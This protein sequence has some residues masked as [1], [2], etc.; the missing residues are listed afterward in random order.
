M[1]NIKPPKH[2]L[3]DIYK[4]ISLI[5]VYVVIL[6]HVLRLTIFTYKY[7][8]NFDYG[9]ILKT[10]CGKEFFEAET[11]RFHFNKN[12]NDIK[13]NDFYDNK[14]FSILMLIFST[15]F[16]FS[17]ASL[18]SYII[19][20]LFYNKSFIDVVL[21]QKSSS[22]SKNSIINNIKNSTGPLSFI[23]ELFQSLYT[24]YNNKAGL[25]RKDV[26]LLSLFIILS[27]ISIMYIQI[28]YP[29][30]IYSDLF[31]ISI[32][33]LDYFQN[34]FEYIPNII[35][36]PFR[37]FYE[38]TKLG[39]KGSNYNYINV[40]LVLVI[41]MRIVYFTLS[42]SDDGI[43][44]KYLSHNIKNLL[45][46]NNIYGFIAFLIIIIIYKFSLQN[47]KIIINIYK[48]NEN[49][50]NNETLSSDIYEYLNSV[51]GFNYKSNDT[52]SSSIFLALTLL[53][54]IIVTILL[55]PN[56]NNDNNVSIILYG[57]CVMLLLYILISSSI[58][59]VSE[60]EKRL[61]K[62]IVSEPTK[63]YKQNINKI[64]NNFD[65]VI[66]IE[67]NKYVENDKYINICQNVGNAILCTLYSH[68]FENIN[69][70]DNDSEYPTD[71]IDITPE[72]KYTNFCEKKLSYNFKD[73]PKYQIHYYM[74]QK[75]RK[76]SMLYNN[77]A[78][79]NP[80]IKVFNLLK[81]N[82]LNI[83]ELPSTFANII[84]NSISNVLENKLYYDY[85]SDII[86]LNDT[87]TNNKLMNIL[88][89]ETNKKE[90]DSKY[91][92]V[93]TKVISKYVEIY[94]DLKNVIRTEQKTKEQ[95]VD[96][97]E[98]ISIT[99]SNK[100]NEINKILSRGYILDDNA[101]IMKYII[102]N[103]NNLNKLHKFNSD[104]SIELYHNRM[105]D[106]IT[107]KSGKLYEIIELERYFKSS[108]R[109]FEDLYNNM[110]AIDPLNNT[111]DTP[112]YYKKFNEKKE[113]YNSHI[114][115]MEQMKKNIINI[116]EI[117]YKDVYNYSQDNATIIINDITE[118][119]ESKI[120]KKTTNKSLDIIKSDILN[121]LSSINYIQ[122][123]IEKS[124]R[125]Y[126]STE[127]IELNSKMSKLSLENAYKVDR[128]IY[129]VL[130]NYII[131]IGL[132]KI[133]I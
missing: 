117:E 128:M 52:I 46:S 50:E 97:I 28:L 102:Y 56:M 2:I 58:N 8:T 100:F 41:M 77:N 78:C 113:I 21:G 91:L 110:D 14:F 7:R 51:W 74:K 79:T 120:N 123:N 112:S 122:S 114:L 62:F 99:I 101:K 23:K 71:K 129:V 43:I 64:R 66:D 85:L 59:T 115:N 42:E 39:I 90:I 36:I 98:Q 29:Y 10:L 106:I 33:P 88:A 116:L 65:R 40:W 67:Y 30:S 83:N 60:Y 11:S 127:D 72:F 121:I 94:T 80:N 68:L 53:F 75:N 70:L 92:D 22:S 37:L 57:V 1:D 38:K 124:K 81:K 86:V 119:Y 111:I 105:F 3:F 31:D 131:I 107:S 18:L 104:K 54:F 69:M 63:L 45:L 125:N 108:L 76:K 103:Y 47:L 133:I 20:N 87:K 4:Y 9:K 96:A 84:Y 35:L 132:S 19:S 13:K 93:I 130:I 27:I 6:L 24:I 49:N 44:S 15:L 16:T 32:T 34:V 89:L 118:M 5:V 17:M 25:E 109:V 48:N 73:D 126:Y 61:N 26:V 95:I 55:I 12:I 82:I